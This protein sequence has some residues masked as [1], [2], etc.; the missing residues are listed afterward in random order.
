MSTINKFGLGGLLVVCIGVLWAS[1]SFAAGDYYVDST[2]VAASDDNSCIQESAPCLTITGTITKVLASANPNNSTI[3][4]NG[5]FVEG[6][7]I[8]D[9]DLEGLTITWLNAGTRPLI[10]ATDETYGIYVTVDNVSLKHLEVTSAELYAIYFAGDTDEHISQGLINDAEIHDL[11]ADT[12]QHYGIFISRADHVTVKN[13]TLHAYGGSNTDEASYVNAVGIYFQNADY[14]RIT[15]NIIRDTTLEVINSLE[16]SYIYASPAGIYLYESDHTSIN[17]N[18]ITDLVGRATNTFTSG[19]TYAYVYPIYIYNAVDT[20]V[21]QNTIRRATAE[22]VATQDG[23]SAYTYAYGIYAQV[24]DDLKIHRN[25]ISGI[26]ASADVLNASNYVTLHGIYVA[27][28]D[29]V[30]ITRNILNNFS[31]VTDQ[32]TVEIFSINVSDVTNAYI[33]RNTIKSMVSTLTGEGTAYSWGINLSDT[34]QANVVRNRIADFA[35]V[36]TGGENSSGKSYGIKLGYNSSADILNN[37]IYFTTGETQN[38]LTGI[39]IL[40][41]QSSPARIFHNTLYNIRTCL[42]IEAAGTIEFLNNI[43]HMGTSGSYGVQLDSETYDLTQL[44]S[45]YNIFYNAAEPVLMNDT[46]VGTLVFS[47]WKAGEYVKDDDSQQKNPKVRASNPGS[48]KYLHLKSS[49]PAIGA[50]TL[51]I[52]FGSDDAM[53]LALLSDWDK[54]ARPTGADADIGA[55]ESQF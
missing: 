8:T 48:S 34:P 16:V 40:S 31:A 30:E 39:S 46:A 41:S 20:T 54:N 33:A 11:A 28:L 15:D 27:A 55:D 53:N 47:D 17:G 3:Y 22:A 9:A 23:I 19:P 7:S 5:T 45:N 24:V 49:S 42:N 38:T 6:V 13:S 2:D 25:T 14:G 44:R 51:N 1:P 43:C 37:L 18:K 26:N 35:A 12:Y 10:Q 50:G 36:V 29:Q 32:G 4:A 52:D 21:R